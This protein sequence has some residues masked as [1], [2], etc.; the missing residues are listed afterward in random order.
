[1]FTRRALIQASLILPFAAIGTPAHADTRRSS[2]V[3]TVQAL[4]RIN[5]FRGKNGLEPLIIDPRAE[6][7]ALEHSVEMALLGELSHKNFK[8]RLA[9]A[10]IVT[11]SAENVAAG[12]QTIAKV[13][14]DW[15]K[16]RDHR[17]NLLGAYNRTGLAVARNAN[18]GNTPYWTLI[19]SV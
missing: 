1:M 7:A 5:Q 12:Q 6:R 19:L 15:E 2:A 8:T 11:P 17:K 9:N 10:Q 3:V 18:S 4:D 16:S 13:L 14:S